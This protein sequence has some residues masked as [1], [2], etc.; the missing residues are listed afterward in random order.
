MD[1]AGLVF[2]SGLTRNRPESSKVLS[3]CT[4]GS[5]TRNVREGA[6]CRVPGAACADVG[7]TEAREGKFVRAGVRATGARN[8]KFVHADIGATEACIN[9]GKVLETINVAH[10]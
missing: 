6:A 1:R 4:R 9:P 10:E 7:A 5:V 2:S 8:V 3:D